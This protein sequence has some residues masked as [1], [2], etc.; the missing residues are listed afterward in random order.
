MLVF[1][2]ILF[3]IVLFTSVIYSIILKDKEPIIIEQLEKSA[4][5]Y[6]VSKNYM[7]EYITEYINHYYHNND[8]MM[9]YE[10]PIYVPSQY[11]VEIVINNEKVT[12]NNERFFKSCKVGDEVYLILEKKLF[13]QKGFLNMKK[14]QKIE[15]KS[16]RIKSN[17]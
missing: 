14:N 17:S 15:L 10:N 12:I 3:S 5:G 1:I 2:F 4:N 16:F 8:Y 11:E 9:I 6:I 13:E 7:P